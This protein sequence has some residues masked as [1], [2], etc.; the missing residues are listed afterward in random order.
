[1]DVFDRD[2]YSL[3]EPR[4]SG[5]VLGGI[6]IVLALASGWLIGNFGA[7]GGVVTIGGPVALIIL[8][9]ILIEPKIGL[10]VFITLGFALGF[11]R[12]IPTEAP[13]GL[14]LDALL[15]MTLL[16]VF[17]NGKRMVWKRLNSPIFYLLLTWFFYTVL[18]YFNPEVPNHEAWFYKVRSFSVNWLLVTIIVLVLPISRR[19][20][21]WLLGL[22]L[23]WSFMSALWAFKQQYLGLAD[24]EAH[25]LFALGNAKTHVL[26]GQLRSFSFYSDA[27]QFGGEMAGVTLICLIFMMSFKNWWSKLFFLV[28]ALVFFW[29]FAVSGTRSALFVVLGGFPTYLVLR[30]NSATLIKGALVAAPIMAI[31]LF[32]HIGDSVYQIYRIRTALRPS[33]DASFMVRMEN[34]ARLRNYMKDLPFGAGLGTSGG[35]GARF[36]PNH[37]AAQIPPDSWYVELWIETGIVGMV[38]Y[39]LMLLAI[40]GLGTLKVWQLKDPWL[41][42]IMLA[43]LAE[44]V[45][46]SVMSYSNPTLGQFPTS[47]MLAINAVLFTTC[48][49]WDMAPGQVEDE[50][51]G[52]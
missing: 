20:I 3:D 14:A 8:M 11:T 39:I 4:L 25:W 26:W 27:S 38:L 40:I 50:E 16:S 1:M 43:I 52:R 21:R 36:S 28:L 48:Y 23:F 46:I 22:W 6:G 41:T 31:L 29:G 12:F 17:L 10:F 7:L 45:G 44:F 51:S 9:G 18:E 19:E 33:E 42:T 49:R 34:Q 32:T 30:R 47:T 13:L 24:A 5:W 35:M 37:G 15:W 2:T